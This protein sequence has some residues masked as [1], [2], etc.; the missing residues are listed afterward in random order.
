MNQRPRRSLPFW[1][2][3]LHI[4]LSLLGLAALVFFSVTG[5]TLNHAEWFEGVE[6]N[7]EAVGELP[8][9]LLDDATTLPG[10]V[11]LVDWI[12]STEGLSGHLSDPIIDDT[13]VAFVLRGPGYV[14]DVTVDLASGRYEVFETTRGLL[15]V[16][17]DL[18]KGRYCGTAWSW[19]LDLS[20]A[21]LT[22]VGVSGIWLLWF[23]KKRR[24]DGLLTSLVGTVV[25]VLFCLIAL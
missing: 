5:L 17:N 21:L 2:R 11:E 24:F 4:Y 1:V 25:L 13:E 15:S 7:R 10:G 14:A 8:A 9:G 6:S 18:H 12:R 3:W 19:F 20:A 23:L 16:A 22:A